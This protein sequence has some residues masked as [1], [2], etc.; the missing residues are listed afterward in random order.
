MECPA[1]SNQLKEVTVADVAVD[2]CDGGCGGIWFDQLELKKFDEPHE[3]AGEV[4]LDTERNESITI[5]RV[6]QLRCPR[7]DLPMM[8]HFFS[9]KHE[10][11]VDECPGCAGFWLDAGELRHIR[12]MFDSEED[13]EKAF[14]SYFDKVFGQELAAMEAE[15]EEKLAKARN[16]A[17]MFRFIC[18][19]YYIP[20]KQKWGAF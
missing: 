15:S 10:V 6:K 13:R 19:S 18:P 17:N 3:A 11:E 16:I 1:C 20:G 9:V 2:V 14:D 12:S 8:R 5:D 7:C 4:L